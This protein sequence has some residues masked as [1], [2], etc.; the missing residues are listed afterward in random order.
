MFDRAKTFVLVTVLALLVWVF[1]ESESLQADV[2]TVDVLIESGSESRYV[3]IPDDAD[4][5]GRVT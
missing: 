3:S 4:W 2:V 1:A 5:S